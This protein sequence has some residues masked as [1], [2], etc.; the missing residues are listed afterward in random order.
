MKNALI[1]FLVLIISSF[2]VNAGTINIPDD[3]STIQAG[4]NAADSSDTVLV[5]PGTYYENIFWPDKNGIKLISAG[6]TSNTIIDGGGNSGVFY[7]NPASVSIDSNTIIKGFTITNGGN[8]TQGGGIFIKNSSPKLLGLYVKNNNP[9]GIYCNSS[10]PT[11]TDVTVKENGGGGIWIYNYSNPTLTNVT[12]SKNSASNGGGIRISQYSNPTLKNVFIIENSSSSEEYGGGG[13]YCYCSD[14]TLTNVTIIGNSTNGNGGGIYFSGDNS[15]TILTELTDVTITGNSAGK[16]GGGIYCSGSNSNKILTDVTITGNSASENGGGIYCDGSS[17]TL[18]NVTISK[19]SSSGNHGRGGGIYFTNCSNPMLTDVTIIEN[20]ASANGGCGGGVYCRLSDPSLTDVTIKEN[21]ANHGGGI[22]CG[23]SNLT[24]ANVTISENRAYG[25]YGPSG[26]GG[27]YFGSYS[28]LILTDVIIKGNSTDKNGGGIY[29]GCSTITLSLTNLFISE[30]FALNGGGIYINDSNPTFLDV[31]FKGN[32]ADEEGGGIYLS[33]CHGRTLKNLTFTGNSASIGG[34][35]YLEYSNPTLTNVFIIKN[36][37]SSDENGGGGIYCNSSNP[38]LTDVIIAEN[39]AKENGGGIYFYSSNPTLT[40]ITISRNSASKGGGIYCR[41]SLNINETSIINNSSSNGGAGMYMT[42]GYPII[43]NNNFLNNGTAIYNSDN[44]NI[45]DATNNWFGHSSGPYHPTQNYS[46]QGDSVNVFV[47]IDPWLIE[48]DTAAPPI[49]LQNLKVSDSGN[50]YVTLSWNASPLPDLNKYR[51]YYD[52]DTTDFY[53]YTDSVDVIKTDTTVTISGLA[54]GQT[55]YFSGITIDNDGNKSWYSEEVYAMTRVIEVQNLDIAVVEDSLHLVT[56]TPDITYTFYDS[57]GEEQTS[58]QIQ[59]STHSDFSNID[60]WDT[61]EISSSDTVITYA[62]NPLQDGNTYYLRVKAAAGEFWSDWN[63]FTFRMNSNPSLPVAMSPVSDTILVPPINL[64]IENSTDPEGD[65]LTYSFDVYS[66]AYLTMKLDSV[67]A[68]TEGIDTTSWQIITTLIDNGQYWWTSSANDG[69]EESAVSNAA[70]FLLNFANDSP[71]A[72]SL[73]SPA[74]NAEVITLTPLLDWEVANDPDPLD[75]VSYNLYFGSS[76][77]DLKLISVDTSTFYQILSPLS[78]NTNYYWKVVAEDLSGAATENTDGYRLFRVNTENEFP[79]HFSLIT[80]TEYSVEIDLTPIFVWENN[81]D[82]DGD[83]ITFNL[84]YSTDSSFTEMVPVIT[85][86]NNFIPVDSLMDNSTYFWKVIAEDSGLL[87]TETD[88]WCFW[89]NTELEPPNPFDLLLPKE[90]EQNLPT[91]PKFVWSKATDND[92]NDYAVYNLMISKDETF[93]EVD[94]FVEGLMDTSFVLT[95]ELSD[96]NKYY[97]KVEAI[98]TDSLITSTE[99]FSFVVGTLS[100]DDS[101][102]IPTEYSLSQN[103]PNP[104]NPV[105][106]IK[107][108]IPEQSHVTLKIINSAGQV[109]DVLVNKKQS[110]GYYT[111]QWDASGVSSGIYLYR[112][113]TKEFS[114]VKKCLFIK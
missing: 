102:G 79:N 53:E 23:N 75:T 93:S 87:Q 98:D 25:S 73:L 35:I 63:S 95:E 107:Y 13:I 80:P 112:I 96:N 84:Y 24:L 27:I 4:L 58:Y 59:V 41:G 48:P 9:I 50:D 69:Y 38:T 70:S 5:Q 90:G 91:A 15:N 28:N 22:Y 67:T 18:T 39:S 111:I 26:G 2:L 77:P 17:P 42:S 11:L 89:T 32:S 44:S 19:N 97:W 20:Q 83:E 104:F 51:I 94:V 21:F 74:D 109:V 99:V 40:D 68:V 103:Y 86:S 10:N 100:I 37:A 45:L 55:F 76:I 3:Y 72:F 1:T 6:D 110:P 71:N 29:S 101:Q 52:Q 7:I 36:Y 65:V 85:D 61:G 54:L 30:N 46:G 31:I 92:P 105:T 49:P 14:P 60:I 12:I 82:P 33:N 66:D 34:G 57:F 16:N 56:H 78:D 114:S 88:T 8:V 106:N 108:A 64:I 47:N 43:N 62:G 113:N 81:G